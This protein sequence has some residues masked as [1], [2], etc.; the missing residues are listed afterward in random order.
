[1]DTG[2][3]DLLSSRLKLRILATEVL[4]LN[5]T[6]VRGLPF[7]HPPLSLLRLD[8]TWESDRRGAR[9]QRLAQLDD[10]C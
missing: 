4:V 5:S 10:R 2:G 8:L 3:V 9:M 6:K 1:M 7:R